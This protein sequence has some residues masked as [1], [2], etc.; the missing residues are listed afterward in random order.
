MSFVDTVI[1]GERQSVKMTNYNSFGNP[2]NS[3]SDKSNWLSCQHSPPLTWWKSV[4]FPPNL[5]K[6][7]T[8]VFRQ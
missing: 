4:S 2:L 3:Y 1:L 7:I 5:D 6:K 8:Q